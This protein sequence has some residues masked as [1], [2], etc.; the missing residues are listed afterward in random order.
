[1]KK[2]LLIAALAMLGSAAPAVHA[3]DVMAVQCPPHNS[4]QLTDGQRYLIYDVAKVSVSDGTFTYGG[5]GRGGLAYANAAGTQILSDHSLS[6]DNFKSV[7]IDNSDSYVW[8]ARR[9]ADN[10][11]WKFW[12]AGTQKYMNFVSDTNVSFSDEGSTFTI[13]DYDATRDAYRVGLSLDGGNHY[14]DGDET[15]LIGWTNAGDCHWFRFLPVGGDDVTYKSADDYLASVTVNYVDGSEIVATFA[16]SGFIGHKISVAATLPA[17]CV[18]NAES[19]GTYQITGAQTNVP[20]TVKLPF[21]VSAT[22]DWSNGGANMKWQSVEA[23]GNMGKYMWT[24]SEGSKMTDDIAERPTKD[25]YPDTQLWAFIGSL[26]E[27][28]KI[29]N[30]AAG[31]GKYMTFVNDEGTVTAA[32]E[33]DTWKVYHTTVNDYDRFGYACFK[34]KTGDSEKGFF[35]HNSGAHAFTVWGWA[36]QGSSNRFFAL[37]EPLIQFYDA[38]PLY[39]HDVEAT[40]AYNAAKANPYDV[41]LAQALSAALNATEDIETFNALKANGEA[42]VALGMLADNDATV[43]EWN[44]LKNSQS[45]K[46]AAFNDRFQAA[47]AAMVAAASLNV[48]GV[49]VKF[50]SKKKDNGKAMWIT[51]VDNNN[52]VSRSD[53]SEGKTAFTLKRSSA[54]NGFILFNEYWNRYVKSGADQS[55][56]VTFTS[57]EAEATTYTFKLLAA[58]DSDCQYGIAQIN[59]SG[60]SEM[61]HTDASNNVVNWENSDNT[62]WA[63]SFV[64]EDVAATEHYAGAKAYFGSL[65]GAG[66]T[67]VGHYRLTAEVQAICDAAIAAAEAADATAE[68]KRESANTLYNARATELTLPQPGHFYRFICATNST[69]EGMTDQRLAVSADLAENRADRLQMVPND[70][71]HALTTVFYVDE[72]NH[73]ISLKNGLCLGIFSRIETTN[74]WKCVEGSTTDAA[75]VVFKESTL[76][77][78]TYSI[79]TAVQGDVT[80][81]LHGAKATVDAMGIKQG[82]SLTDNGCCWEIVEANWI[83]VPGSDNSFT[84]ICTPVA[85]NTEGKKLKA[86]T[87]AVENG[88]VVLTPFS[89]TDNVIPANT[90]LVLQT[91]FTVNSDYGTTRNDNNHLVYLKV[92]RSLTG[93]AP[94]SNDLQGCI[95]AFSANHKVLNGTNFE[96]AASMV[97][98]FS[99]YVENS[100]ETLPIAFGDIENLMAPGKVFTIKSTTDNRGYIG[101]RE[102]ATALETSNRTGVSAEAVVADPNYQ[103]TV[104][105]D[106]EGNHYL[107]NLGAKKFAGAYE[108][109]TGAGN[110]CEFG[111]HFSDYPTA[112]TVAYQDWIS[113]MN[114]FGGENALSDKRAG[115]MIINNNGQHPVVGVSGFGIKDGCGFM[116]EEVADAVLPEGMPTAADIDAAHAA[117]AQEHATAQ[118]YILNPDRENAAAD[119]VGHYNA[120][121]FTAFSGKVLAKDENASAQERYYALVRGRNAA[122]DNINKFETGKVY[123]VFDADGMAYMSVLTRNSETKEFETS[124]ATGE[125]DR[126]NTDF[127]WLASVDENGTVSLRHFYYNGTAD[128]PQT[129]ALVDDET[130]KLVHQLTDPV[131]PAYDGMGNVTL[132][133]YAVTATHRTDNPETTVIEEVTADGNRAERDVVYDLTG[134]RVNKAAH[135]VFIINGKKVLVK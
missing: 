44:E 46:T 104:I 108:A 23:H 16:S 58:T 19:D 124:T 11:G 39:A 13:L 9:D 10:T 99:A 107:C 5:I 6:P 60:R 80:R 91:E 96:A 74:S 33:Y 117:M 7:K 43:T 87:A 131:V 101:Y 78:G 64:G 129:F 3:E 59:H 30:K 112:V 48:D 25:V 120:E 82:N 69:V 62:H 128:Q 84:T 109:Y 61:F 97:N 14:W 63:I 100:A 37:A 73:L 20:V 98:G 92:E 52:V 95:M 29:V 57:D 72:E 135:G 110:G 127:N 90:P 40:A 26:S 116:I 71:A 47:Y 4:S 35:N 18:L 66:S 130:G 12:N 77:P 56:I 67:E 102:G 75:K 88:K 1:M 32:P 86:M 125:F 76:Q 115:I 38:N 81:Y 111:W 41:E 94:E 49:S 24:H 8:E 15:K 106:S 21:M 132:G 122:A 118:A 53:A 121:G 93:V 45:K 103:W 27:G 34:L 83:P 89:L 126:E 55:N 2:L 79:I 17:F 31:Q 65:K 105:S 22:E 28:F 51:S 70:D 85:L 123:N 134:R 68:V 50:M 42:F 54:N 113:S 133:D 114:I 36:D 119:G